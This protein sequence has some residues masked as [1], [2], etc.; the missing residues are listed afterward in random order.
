MCYYLHYKL[1]SLS[2]NS[3]LKQTIITDSK[4]STPRHSTLSICTPS[5][6]FV[7]SRLSRLKLGPLLL[8]CQCPRA[9]SRVPATAVRPFRAP[10][11]TKLLRVL[12]RR[13]A[14][15]GRHGTV[16]VGLAGGGHPL[17]QVSVEFAA[18]DAALAAV[19]LALDAQALAGGLIL[20][21]ARGKVACCLCADEGSSAAPGPLQIIGSLA[22]RGQG[23]GTV[24]TTVDSVEVLVGKTKTGT[25]DRVEEVED[26][27]MDLGGE[28]GD[29]HA[30]RGAVCRWGWLIIH[31]RV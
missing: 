29:D 27:K 8:G 25:I 21:G 23:N 2:R 10:E 15:L 9:P 26:G 24:H 16:L 6:C 13:R 1:N 28:V 7:T 5:K 31:D 18:R 19:D 12:G 4:R 17:S 22:A 14:V 30:G 3:S 20:A 11:V